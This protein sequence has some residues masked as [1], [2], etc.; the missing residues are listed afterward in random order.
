MIYHFTSHS[1]FS[2]PFIAAMTAFSRKHRRPV[3]IVY[4][5]RNEPKDLA[6]RARLAMERIRRLNKGRVPFA[7]GCQC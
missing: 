2:K 1:S 7:T 6:G 3:T 4:S 5:S